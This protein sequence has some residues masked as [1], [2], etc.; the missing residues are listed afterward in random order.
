MSAYKLTE[1]GVQRTSD[2][3]FIPEDA[4]NIDWQ[5]YLAWVA[6]GNTA[7]PLPGP[8]PDDLYAV[9][10]AAGI[11]IVSS[12][13]SA[14]N[15]TYSLADDEKQNIT[16]ILVQIGV[17]LGL[18]GGQSTIPLADINGDPHSFTVEALK[19]LSKAMADYAY[20][21]STTRSLLNA[22]QPA[23]WPAQPVTIT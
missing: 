4:A 15:G 5:G 9:K 3:A 11:Q 17:G 6:L 8:T 16:G 7:D 19:N 23:D 18:P 20:A 13:T 14:L 2:G 1:G 22:S 21:L 10:L 12:G